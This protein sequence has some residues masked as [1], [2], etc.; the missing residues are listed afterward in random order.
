MANKVNAKFDIKDINIEKCINGATRNKDK[1]LDI[2]DEI[3]T[4]IKS[5]KKYFEILK[6]LQNDEDEDEQPTVSLINFYD[7]STNITNIG[8]IIRYLK[9]IGEKLDITDS[10]IH[11]IANK[12]QSKISVDSSKI[13][14]NIQENM[15]KYN[16]SDRILYKT[17]QNFL[18]YQKINNKNILSYND[19]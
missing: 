1:K 17:Y 12:I 18:L 11:K 10:D 2:R 3:I 8:Q 7:K 16:A 4:N 5:S 14:K 9:K 15:T 13:P 19:L 6:N